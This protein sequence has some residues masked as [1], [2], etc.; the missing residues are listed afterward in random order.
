MRLG[1]TVRDVLRAIPVGGDALVSLFDRWDTRFDGW[2]KQ[3]HKNDGTHSDITCDSIDIAGDAIIGGTLTVTGAVAFTGDLSVGDDLAVTDDATI[4]GDLAVTGTITGNGAALTKTDDTNVTLTLGGTPTLA[5]LK[6]VSLTLG[7]AGRLALSRFVQGT[8]RSV[9]G[10]AGA[11]TADY[12][13]ISAGTDAQVLRRDGT[14]IAF[15]AV[16]LASTDAVTGDLAFSNLAQGSALSVLGVTGNATADNA[17]IAAGSDH[18]VV[19]RSG[20]AVAFGAVN[21]AQSAAVTGTLPVGN[22]GSGTATAF[23]AGSVVFAGTSGVYS[24]DNSNFFWDDTNNRLGIGSAAPGVTLEVQADSNANGVR[25]RGRSSD[26]IG[27]MKFGQNDGTVDASVWNPTASMLA[28]ST[29]T[30]VIANERMRLTDVG[31]L[32]IGGTAVRATTEGTKH[33]DIFDGTAPVGTLTNGCSL[34]STSGEMRVMDAAGNATL[35]SPHDRV[36]GEWVYFCKNS[37]TGK[38]LRVDLE[39]LVKFLDAHFGTA[40]VRE[41][42]EDV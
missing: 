41:W 39:R 37:V 27:V 18:Q 22:G 24:Q 3:Q 38:V 40:F 1:N 42:T 32:K 2:S 10:V 34:Y 17:S 23:T 20:T 12:A 14:S 31:Q 8:A 11:S 36:T 15:G 19:R 25:I 29:G 21:L 28:F 35:L 26:S 13:D 5:L 6:A 33:L 30:L 9:L 4:G 16:N 7:W